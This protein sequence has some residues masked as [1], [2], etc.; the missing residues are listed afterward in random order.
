MEVKKTMTRKKLL[1][2]AVRYSQI[3]YKAYVNPWDEI[4]FAD[5]LEDIINDR[6]ACTL[7]LLESM[8]EDEKDENKPCAA[9]L[10]L[11]LDIWNIRMDGVR[12]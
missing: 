2:Q 8:A 4:S 7:D 9:S 6:A 1:K 11:A 12:E 5:I 3:I 10:A